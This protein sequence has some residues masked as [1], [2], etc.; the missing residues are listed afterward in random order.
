MSRLLEWLWY[1]R[2]P[3][4]AIRRLLLWPL[5]V[6]AWLFGRAVRRRDRAFTSGRRPAV[7]V[8]PKVFSVGNLTVGGAGKTPCVIALA[9]RLEA[10]GVKVAVLTRGY[11][12]DSD[13]PLVLRGAEALPGAAFA[14][15]EPLLIAKRLPS[16]PVLVGADRVA[17]ARLAERLGT[18]VLLLDDGMQHRRLA[19]DVDVVVVDAAVGFGNGRLLP[20][21]PLRE[22]L[23]GLSRAGLI[24]LREATSPVALPAF[25]AP[26]VRVRH[27]AS[28]LL[29]PKGDAHPADTLRGRKVVA[30]CGIA[31]P[32]GFERTCADL[33]V[34]RVATASFG[35]HHRFTASELS[36]VLAR[37][38]A[39]GAEILT[40]EKDAVRLPSDFPAWKVHLDVEVLE[41]AAHLDAAL[42]PVGQSAA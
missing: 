12:R 40:T 3:E 14:G 10:Q 34:E 1:P 4:G 9:Q 29:D 20:R 21:G 25:E 41:G 18:E 13:E 30:L 27:F 5:A 33:G 35:D 7:R 37:A 17:S 6:T 23:S 11:G 22:P 31:R 16:I 28:A 24:W 36:R 32:T 42:G 19:R 39:G 8:G 15:D 26:V 2:R 38:R